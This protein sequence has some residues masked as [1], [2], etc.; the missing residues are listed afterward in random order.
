M[1]ILKRICKLILRI[2]QKLCSVT[3]NMNDSYDISDFLIP[4]T[5]RICKLKLR[6]VQKTLLCLTVAV[7]VILKH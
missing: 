7:L 4:H 5:K 2:V 1:C 3:N 6:I